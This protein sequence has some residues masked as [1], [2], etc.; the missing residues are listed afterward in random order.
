MLGAFTSRSA[1]RSPVGMPDPGIDARHSG[2][3]PN[4]LEPTT[5]DLRISALA[6]ILPCS[7]IGRVIGALSVIWFVLVG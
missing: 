3:P 1:K 7:G 5:S 4:D 6:D 2:Q